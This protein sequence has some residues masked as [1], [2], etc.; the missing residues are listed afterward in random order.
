[1]QLHRNAKLGFAGRLALVAMIEAGRSIR[2]GEA[3]WGRSAS[4]AVRVITSLMGRGH[5]LA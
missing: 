2:G 1:M 3:P 5:A 4:R